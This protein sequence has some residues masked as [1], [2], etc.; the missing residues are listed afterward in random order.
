MEVVYRSI[1]VFLLMVSSAT[2]SQMI[3]SAKFYKIHNAQ[4]L[5]NEE[6]ISKKMSD[7]D[8][9]LWA[10]LK[11]AIG[12]NMKIKESQLLGYCQLVRTFVADLVIPANSGT[13]YSTVPVKSK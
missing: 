8:C 1:A 10:I 9:M 4:H 11:G 6:W 3:R 2:T 12:Y 5:S 13:L 7:T